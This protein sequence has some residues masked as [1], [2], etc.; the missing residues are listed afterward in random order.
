MVNYLWDNIF[1]SDSKEMGIIKELRESF[2]FNTLTGKDLRFLKELVHIRK[3]NTGEHV[4]KQGEMGAV[5][6]LVSKGTVDVF[7]EDYDLMSKASSEV[8]VTRLKRGDFFGETALAEKESKRTATVKASSEL[9]LIG[10]S[11]PDLLEISERSP[12]M[13]NKILLQLSEV[14]GRR[15]YSTGVKVTE[16]K[17]QLNSIKQDAINSGKI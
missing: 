9:E 17:R 3:Y 4:F 5:M 6:Y 8:F 15:L 10:L 11:K 16:L 7:V 2:L 14:L 12:S 1:R 13:G